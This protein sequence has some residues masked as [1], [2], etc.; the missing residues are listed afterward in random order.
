MNNQQIWF[1]RFQFYIKNVS[2]Y[3]RY[4][5][6]GHIVIVFFFMIGWAAYNYQEWLKDVPSDFPIDIIMGI[7]FAIFLTM[8]SISSFLKSADQVYLLPLE[9]K[10]NGYFIRSFVVSFLFQGLIL[11]VVAL[12]LSPT[13]QAVHDDGVALLYVLFLALVLK[14]I[15]LCMV[16][17]GGFF[18]T[19]SETLFNTVLRFGL[20]GLA[21]YSLLLSQWIVLMAIIGSMIFATIVF[22][23]TARK[24]PLPWERLVAAESQSMDRFYRLANLF[25]DVP[26][27]QNR[28]KERKW[29][30]LKSGF[31]KPEK[32]LDYLLIR[33]FVRANDYL[34]MV[35]R[36]TLIAAVILL[37]L[38]LAYGAIIVAV[39]F[40]YLTALQLVPIRSHH[41]FQLWLDLYPIPDQVRK[42]AV[43]GLIFKVLLIQSAVL[44][45]ITL[46]AISW[47]VAVELIAVCVAFAFLFI[48]YL[49]KKF[50]QA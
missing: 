38:P 30:P 14:A 31:T 25:T 27:L 32:A 10:L 11:F 34:G 39:A 18:Q 23:L 28:V 50:S 2:R 19:D 48:R 16:F 13:Y 26:H 21:I 45:V 40:L 46:I 3:L 6:S 22:M 44:A 24:Y 5:L 15:N 1:D 12:L 8:G 42:K 17:F 49:L 41:D 20:S 36:L 33:T 29:L 35:V 9:S 37:L 4:M 7:A 47:I 43:T